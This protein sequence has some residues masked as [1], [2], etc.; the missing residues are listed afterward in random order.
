MTARDL[1]PREAKAVAELQA[2]AKRW[3]K[4]LKLFSWSGSLVIFDIEHPS[5]GVSA[6]DEVLATVHG[7]PNDGG[8][9]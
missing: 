6:N 2:L 1:T 8:D 5:H 4:T 3:P 7:I 9:P